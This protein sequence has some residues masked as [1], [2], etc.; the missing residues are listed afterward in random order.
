MDMLKAI[1][2]LYA[3]V[4]SFKKDLLQSDYNKSANRRARKKSVALRDSIKV[5]RE[6]LLKHEKEM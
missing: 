1:N 2:D 4:E 6:E 3:E 5:M